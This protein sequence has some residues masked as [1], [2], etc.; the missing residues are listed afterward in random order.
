VLPAVGYPAI[1]ELEDDAAVNIQVLAVSTPHAA[2]I[3]E[4]VRRGARSRRS[5]CLNAG[6]SGALTPRP[7]LQFVVGLRNARCSLGQA[8]T[9]HMIAYGTVRSSLSGEQRE[10]DLRKS[11]AGM[12]SRKTLCNWHYA[13]RDQQRVRLVLVA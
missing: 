5:L 4:Q 8:F 10:S 2:P 11:D 7:A 1:L 3:A 12:K 9:V 6:A 13:D